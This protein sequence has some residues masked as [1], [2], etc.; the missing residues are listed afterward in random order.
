MCIFSDS[1]NSTAIIIV[2]VTKTSVESF[3]TL[4]IS[5]LRFVSGTKLGVVHL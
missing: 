4:V 1:L 5:D 2:P 3:S